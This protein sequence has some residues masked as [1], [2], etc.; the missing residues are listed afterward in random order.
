ML[1]PPRE[2][3]GDSLWNALCSFASSSRV[4]QGGGAAVAIIAARSAVESV[5][6]VLAVK[7]VVARP[8]ADDV[9]AVQTVN[10]IVSA[11]AVNHIPAIRST[12]DI[13]PC[14]SNDRRLPTA[15]C[16][17]PWGW[18]RRWYWGWSWS[19]SW[20]WSC[21]YLNR[22]N[23]ARRA[24]GPG[25]TTLV[26]CNCQVGRRHGIYGGAAGQQRVCLG[27]AAIVGKRAEQ[28]V[29]ATHVAGAQRRTRNIA[30]DVVAQGG[31]APG[32]VAAVGGGVV[33][34]DRVLQRR[35]GDNA[36]AAVDDLDTASSIRP[37]AADGAAG[38]GHV[39]FFCDVGVY[40]ATPPMGRVV[41]D[42]AVGQGHRAVQLVYA[43]AIAT[44][45]LVV[46]RVVADGAVGQG[47]RADVVVDAP[48]VAGRVVADR[49]VNQ[50]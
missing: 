20:S 42:R 4:A 5:A 22:T 15:T 29:C 8:T 23:V 28:R 40:A 34:N 21:N 27:G 32:G 31:D 48:A 6:A 1:H 24:L 26:V 11:E 45:I 14:G 3:G 36:A 25:D 39:A 50:G 49:A 10:D 19:W 41:A 2:R 37:V 38:E 18:G 33:G 17:L 16:D 43:T 44:A 9:V 7:F 13:S 46:G 47:H 35:L 30:K 12:N